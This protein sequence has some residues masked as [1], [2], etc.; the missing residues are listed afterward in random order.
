MYAHHSPRCCCCNLCIDVQKIPVTSPHFVEL[1]Y[2]ALH[3]QKRVYFRKLHSIPAL[4]Y[5]APFRDILSVR[6]CKDCAAYNPLEWHFILE[7]HDIS[8]RSLPYLYSKV[9]P[10]LGANSLV[11]MRRVFE[12]ICDDTT[13]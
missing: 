8:G 11:H 13:L 3:T 6:L 9:A 4:P 1:H 12:S 7:C 5:R 10:L 2:N